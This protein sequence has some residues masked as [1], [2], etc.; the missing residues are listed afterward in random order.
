VKLPVDGLKALGDCG[1]WPR[2]ELA[3]A[4]APTDDRATVPAAA[5]R[6]LVSVVTPFYN[7]APYLAQCI[8]SVLAQTY[9]DFEYVLVDNCSTDGSTEIAESY[10]RRDPRIRLIRRSQ[11][12]SQIQNYNRAL[13]EI[14]GNSK[15]CKIVQADDYIFPE[16]LRL[17]VDAFEQSAAIGLVSSYSLAGNTVQAS[18]YP[19]PTTLSQ[20]KD[21]AQWHLRNGVSIFG[22]PTTVMYRSS[23]VRCH[24]PFYDETLLHDDLD[25]C[26]QLLREYDFGFVHQI[27]SF[28]RIGNDSIYHGAGLYHWRY[29]S[30]VR[31]SIVLRYA[32]VFLA[33]DEA[34]ALIKETTR[35]YYGVL[36]KEAFHFWG[37]S[38]W[39]HHR[40]GLRAVGQTLDR[41]YL[42]L[43]IG[44]ELLRMGAN[45]GSTAVRAV[46]F[47]KLMITSKTATCK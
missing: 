15:Y 30:L 37:R 33:P 5:S 22:S 39:Q 29:S 36:A 27:L 7:T 28:T 20:G 16:C 19:Y 9:A 1:G 24:Q 25:K 43:Q 11:F 23:V 45:P 3:C 35:V 47:L 13:T 32:P 38:F 18:G 31:F 26:M 14:S 21:C 8:E 10:A 46:R 6:P 12:L 42:T 17:M 2:A 34:S 41:H 40:E 4:D 44:R